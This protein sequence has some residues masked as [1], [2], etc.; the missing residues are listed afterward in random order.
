MDTSETYIKMCE[1]AGEIQGE[2]KM[3]E[4]DYAYCRGC[5]AAIKESPWK[6]ESAVIVLSGYETDGG[7]YGHEAEPGVECSCPVSNGAFRHGD[8]VFR[9]EHFWLPRQD[10][11]Q[12]MVG[13]HT[14]YGLILKLN[15]FVEEVDFSQEANEFRSM[16]QLWLAFVMKELYSK[17]WNGEDWV[18]A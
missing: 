14:W 11:L 16:E 5:A 12:G 15:Q 2:W 3:S 9:D 4:W 17:H 6:D 8:R 13:N 18:K 7:Y 1:K 10:Q